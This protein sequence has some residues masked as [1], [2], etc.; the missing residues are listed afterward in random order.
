MKDLVAVIRN[1][2]LALLLSGRIVSTTGDWFYSI[3]LSV[4]IYGYSHGNTVYV[5]LLWIVR[6]IPSLVFG[7]IA[8][9]LADRM[10]Y[11]RA[12]IVADLGRGIM[13]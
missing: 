12:M 3:A 11:R 8:G 2:N 10:G 1:R 4:A 6:L 7:P 13:Y 5:G 9:A